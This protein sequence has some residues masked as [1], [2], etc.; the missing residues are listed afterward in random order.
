MSR[1]KEYYHNAIEAEQRPKERPILF[2]AYMVRAILEGRK[3]QTRRVIK[4][5][6]AGTAHIW[7]DGAEWNVEN[8]AKALWVGALRCPYGQPGDRLWVRETWQQ[9]GDTF[10]YFA[11]DTDVFPETKWRPSIHMPRA[12]SRILLE[13][14]DIRA[15]R[16]HDITEADAIAEGLHSVIPNGGPNTVYHDYQ[17]GIWLSP[18]MLNN[19]IASYRTLWE[20]INGSGSWEQNPWV[21][22]ISFTP[23]AQPGA[24]PP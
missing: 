12:A 21:W 16:L 9:F 17:T 6:P 4:H 5:V 20:K 14:T 22:V 7:N 19:P 13:I 8:A 15:Q 11:T 23:I 10:A 1:I 2:S 24:V 3:T 18:K